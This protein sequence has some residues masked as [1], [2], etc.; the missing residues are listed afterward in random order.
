VALLAG[1]V[2]ITD[3]AGAAEKAEK[4]EKKAGEVTL[5]GD[6]VCA[7]CTLHESAKCQNVLKVTEAGKETKYYLAQNDVA[8][9]NHE[10]VCSGESKA[11]V[12]GTVKSAKGKKLLTASAIT[13]E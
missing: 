12:T 6:L 4:G 11:T 1:G 8:E 10:Q 7:K 9:K 2:L 3:P 5:S 13:W